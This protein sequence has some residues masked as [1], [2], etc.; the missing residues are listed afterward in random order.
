MEELEI[1][2]VLFDLDGTLLDTEPAYERA[3]ELAVSGLGMKY[4]WSIQRKIVGKPEHV[5]AEIIVKELGM[6]TV[7]PLQLLELRDAHLLEMFTQVKPRKGVMDILRRCRARKIP[8][9][10]A[11]SS[12]RRYADFKRKNNQELFELVDHIVF[13]DDSSVK[14]GKPKPD[15]YIEAAR[16][17]GV[18]PSKCLVFEDS[19]AGMKAGKAANAAAVLVSPDPRMPREDYHLADIIV[20]EWSDLDL[21]MFGF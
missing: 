7:D 21:S 17:I 10:I 14:R 11:T 1:E 20:D 15:I 19:L 6:R 9:A 4:S 16:R 12:M 8:V 2:G 13:G 5:G 18:H 3:M